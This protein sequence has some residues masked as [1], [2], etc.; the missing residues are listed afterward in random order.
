MLALEKRSNT[1]IEMRAQASWTASLEQLPLLRAKGKTV[2]FKRES[3]SSLLQLPLGLSG[4]ELACSL[5]T[6]EVLSHTRE[7]VCRYAGMQV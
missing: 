6:F 7:Q 3:I 4:R 5:Q 2:V 1:G